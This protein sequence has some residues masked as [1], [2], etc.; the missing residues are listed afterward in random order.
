MT[1]A[2]L[3]ALAIGIVFSVVAVAFGLLCVA[4]LAT[5]GNTDTGLWCGIASIVAW[6]G[7]QCAHRRFRRD[8][9]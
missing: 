3:E 5:G 7:A 9:R 1:P 2:E 6:I 8:D 4:I